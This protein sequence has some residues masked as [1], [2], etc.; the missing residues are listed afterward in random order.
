MRAGGAAACLATASAAAFALSACSFAPKYAA[1]TIATPPAYKEA[2]DWTPAAPA[3]AEPR[4]PWWSVYGDPVLS[5]LEGRIETANPSLASYVARY[6]QAR[7][8]LAQARASLLPEIDAQGHATE[9]RQ[10]QHRPLRVGG[11][12]Y[13]ADNLIGASTAYELD[14]WGQLRNQVAAGKAAA[15]ASQADVATIRLSLQADLADDYMNL[16]GLDAQDRLLKQSVDAYRRALD[17]TI[18][19]HDGGAVS[20]LD[21]DQ[22]RTQLETARAQESDVV[23]QRKLVEHA[24]AV[25]V[26]QPAS[27]F[28]LAPVD[29][30]LITPPR[31]PISTPAGL[32]Q[33]RPDIAAAERRA[34][35]ANAQI[36][37]TK[38]A[39]YPNILL[40]ASGGLET[41]GGV[42]LLNAGNSF[43]T[44]GPSAVMPLFDGGR[45]K[46]Q[47]QQVE[48]QFRQ[49]ADDYRSTVLGAFQQ[50]EDNLA[51]CN[52]LAQEA[53]RE[54]A[55]VQAA[56]AAED[57]SLVRYQQG[58]V[59]YLDVVTAQTAA[60]TAERTALQLATRR[61]QASVDLVRALGGGWTVAQDTLLREA[62]A[63]RP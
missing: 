62:S 19:R 20:G 37:V 23:A 29:S 40:N 36:G 57:L 50:V 53:E 5:D 33:R 43:W 3:D 17:L 6:D 11:N 16:R 30:D 7:A 24:I 21:V 48:A 47:V 12:T 60:L 45:R 9:Q 38:A 10:S 54:A 15:Q 52:D 14:F 25:L 18:Q 56:R 46:G 8:L 63:A 26:G 34:A 2:G 27:S 4:G 49:A 51:L 44:V 58:A 13:Y 32:L 1:P 28:S 22:A 41:A 61:L 35:A 55:A 59:T 31:I 42:N 39:F